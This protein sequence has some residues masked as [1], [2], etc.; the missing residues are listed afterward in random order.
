M[1]EV[2][3]VLLFAHVVFL[4]S[5]LTLLFGLAFEFPL[6]GL[7]IEGLFLGSEHIGDEL[8]ADFFWIDLAL[9]VAFLC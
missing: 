5:A 2:Y 4:Q 1:V 9:D 8:I 3:L 6:V 7:L